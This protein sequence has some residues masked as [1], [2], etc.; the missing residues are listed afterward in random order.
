MNRRELLK[1][2]AG[3]APVVSLPWI[4][5]PPTPGPSHFVGLSEAQELE[6][7]L[8]PCL[9]QPM[10]PLQIEDWESLPSGRVIFDGEC[11]VW[12]NDKEQAA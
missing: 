1:A 5:V 12:V 6:A 10:P 11:N 7:L 8:R 2:M 9:H 4:V 3:V